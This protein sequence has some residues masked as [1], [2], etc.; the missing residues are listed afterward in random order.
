[1]PPNEEMVGRPQRERH[2]PAYLDAYLWMVFEDNTPESPSPTL[3]SPVS[4]PP[5]GF[6]PLLLPHS[7]IAL[8]PG[9]RGEWHISITHTPP[10][11]IPSLWGWTRMAGRNRGWRR[12]VGI[13]QRPLVLKRGLST[14]RLL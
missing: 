13:L 5:P 14:V 9:P 10:H 7:C 3:M 2:P 6:S 1:M 11:G 4:P 12:S 8:S